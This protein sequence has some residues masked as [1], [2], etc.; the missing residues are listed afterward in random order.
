MTVRRHQK[1]EEQKADQPGVWCMGKPV[2][3]SSME[4]GQRLT[5]LG[6]GLRPGIIHTMQSTRPESHDVKAI[7]NQ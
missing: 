3:E 1:A 6:V 2:G 7:R 5:N 4:E